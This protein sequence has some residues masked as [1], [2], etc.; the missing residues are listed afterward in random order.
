MTFTQREPDSAPPPDVRFATSAE[1]FPVALVGETAFAMLP[2]RGET[3][4][5]GLAWR[6]RRP[7]EEL[8]RKDFYG[9]GGVLAHN[10]EDCDL[11]GG[12]VGLRL[13]N[14]NSFFLKSRLL[15]VR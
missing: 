10:D 15:P 12:D 3:H 7:L 9:H 14:P 4:F 13:R 8:V 1:G 5:L 6:I 11:R 2:G